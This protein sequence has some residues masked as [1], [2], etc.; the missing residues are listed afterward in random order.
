MH[1]DNSL[2]FSSSHE[3]VVEQSSYVVVRETKTR[4]HL[5]S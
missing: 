4:A 5:V 3:R 2:Q 1:D